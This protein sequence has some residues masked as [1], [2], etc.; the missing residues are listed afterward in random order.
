[1]LAE[2]SGYD[3]QSAAIAAPFTAAFLDYLHSDLKFGQ[4]KTYHI[5]NDQIGAQWDFKH[6]V[7]GFPFPLPLANTG[8]DLSHA[9]GYNP[10]LRILVLNGYYDLA[11]PFLATEYMMSHLSLEKAQQSHIQMK[12]FEAGH[13]M[14]IHEPSLKLFKGAIGAFYD[15]T[16]SHP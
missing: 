3:P 14:Y 7:E 5:Q 1:M 13:M 9:L 4:G 12:Y 8:F 6:R 11:T 15:A 2:D 10:N 16:A